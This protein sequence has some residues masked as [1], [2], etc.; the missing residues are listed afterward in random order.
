M[1]ID[2]EL[3]HPIHPQHELKL[4]YTEMPFNCAGCKEAGIGLKHH[5]HDCQF[6]LHK[7][8]ALAAPTINHPFYKK[9]HFQFYHQPP[10]SIPRVCDA[11]NNHV[12]GFVYHCKNCGFDL[13]PCCASLPRSLDDGEVKLFLCVKISGQCHYCGGKGAG[14]SYRSQCKT[15]NLHVSC[16]KRLLVERWEAMY[17]NVDEHKVKEVQ[18]KIPSLKGILANHHGERG[19]KLRKCCQIAGSAIGIIVSAVL[20]E[21]TT[22]IASVI[23]GLMSK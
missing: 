7:V 14:W 4:E 6:D 15:Y 19:G 13:H 9:C 17:L 23:G 5:C 22:L 16:V 3:V 8:C 1:K 12:Q 11:C 20:G 10:G 2:K 21:P 18:T